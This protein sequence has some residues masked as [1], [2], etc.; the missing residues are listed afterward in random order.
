MLSLD[1]IGAMARD[2]A[3]GA[4]RWRRLG[5]TLT[6]ASPQMGFVPGGETMQPWATAN[7]CAVFQQGYLE[8]I[9]IHAPGRFNPWTRYLDRF[10]GFHICALRCADADAAYA[11]LKARAPG[12]DPPVARR[13]DAPHGAGTREMRFRNI[14]S[15]DAHYPEGRFIVIEHQT[16]EVLWHEAVMGHANTA[17]RFDTVYFRAPD[18]AATTGRLSLL[19]GTPAL[20]AGDGV[21]TIDLP[22]GGRAMVFDETAFAAR[23]PGAPMPP[24]PC[25]AGGVVAVA[26]LEMAHRVITDGGIVVHDAGDDG[27]WAGP[28]ATCGGILHFVQA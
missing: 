24:G 6:R 16:P 21:T 12:L 23:F 9:G 22:A 11:D 1:H 26:E 14:F 19:A 27:F 3:A 17:V 20:P 8:L 15:Q 5:F 7:H 10:E 13:R 18:A 4:A 28:E 25:I 2:L